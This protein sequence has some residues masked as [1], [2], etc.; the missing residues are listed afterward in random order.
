MCGANISSISVTS[1][2]KCGSESV[3]SRE[4]RKR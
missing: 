2:G 1:A 3:L 4:G